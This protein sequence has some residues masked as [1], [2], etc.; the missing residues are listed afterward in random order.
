[1][2][3][4][5][6]KS[7]KSCIKQTRQKPETSAGLLEVYIALA[8]DTEKEV[9]KSFATPQTKTWGRGCTNLFREKRRMK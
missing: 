1:M 3:K 9:K 6:F 8:V 4:K 7:Q 2:D 5:V